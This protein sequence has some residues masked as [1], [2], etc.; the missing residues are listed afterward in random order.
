M[1]YLL[2]NFIA[3]V[4]E[5]LAALVCVLLPAVWS[6]KFATIVAVLAGFTWLAVVLNGYGPS[7]YLLPIA[8]VQVG[9][10]M[11]IFALVGRY[12]LRPVLQ[13]GLA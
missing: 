4:L 5:P 13:K 10:P 11:L 3:N 9:M 12:L 1:Q 2:A 6:S 8:W 7:A